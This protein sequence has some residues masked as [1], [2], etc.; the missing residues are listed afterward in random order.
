[1]LGKLPSCGVEGKLGPRHH[2][3][4]PTHVHIKCGRVHI[5]CGRVHI[6]CGRVHIKCGRVHI[7]CTLEGPEARRHS[8]KVQAQSPLALAVLVALVLL[9]ALLRVCVLCHCH[10]STQGADS[11]PPSRHMQGHPPPTHSSNTLDLPHRPTTL[12]PLHITTPA[13]R[14]Y[15][16]ILPRIGVC[17]QMGVDVTWG[18]NCCGDALICIIKLATT[19]VPRAA[20]PEVT[21]APPVLVLCSN[22]WA[23]TNTT[24]LPQ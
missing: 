5:K 17:K 21:T 4:G 8:L 15:K 6:K 20:Q 14:E 19:P 22:S 7:K 13:R 12:S 9:P 11:L 23:T 18:S 3:K 10:I 2:N 16:N 1:M 24:A